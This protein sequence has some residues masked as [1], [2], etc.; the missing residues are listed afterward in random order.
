MAIGNQYNKQSKELSSWEKLQ[1]KTGGTCNSQP[2]RI[3]NFRNGVSPSKILID[4]S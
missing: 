2:W 3:Q 4:I 1:N